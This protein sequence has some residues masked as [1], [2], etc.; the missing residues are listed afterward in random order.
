MDDIVH[1]VEDDE[2]VRYEVIPIDDI[3]N[4]KFGKVVTG[5]TYDPINN[6][7]TYHTETVR[8][9]HEISDVNFLKY[10]NRLHRLESAI[11]VTTHTLSLADMAQKARMERS[12][13][14]IVGNW[15]HGL[16]EIIGLSIG[17]DGFMERISRME[18]TLGGFHEPSVT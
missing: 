7:T 16:E 14:S 13:I 11:G 4:G 6:K 18:D 8:M 12:H 17:E 5:K 1:V 3:G 15:I 2:D 10:L 9:F